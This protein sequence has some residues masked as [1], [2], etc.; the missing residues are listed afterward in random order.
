METGW[1]RGS[2]FLTL[3]EVTGTVGAEMTTLDKNVISH[4]YLLGNTRNALNL[5]VKFSWCSHMCSSALIMRST[6]VQ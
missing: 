5:L 2:R 3:V 4:D 1:L 6:T